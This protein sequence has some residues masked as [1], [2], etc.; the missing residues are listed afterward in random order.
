[1]ELFGLFTSDCKQDIRICEVGRNCYGPNDWFHSHQKM[2]QQFEFYQLETT[3]S[4]DNIFQACDSNVCLTTLH[5][6]EFFIPFNDCNLE[7]DVS[8]IWFW[9]LNF[10]GVS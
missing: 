10:V 3:Q 5:I 7:G 4:L 2:F 6:Q 9:C 8:S 1:L